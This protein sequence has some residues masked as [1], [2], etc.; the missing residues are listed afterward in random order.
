MKNQP[1]LER[2][3]H[4][5][6]ALPWVGARPTLLALVE[7]RREESKFE[8]TADGPFGDRQRQALLAA[9]ET[10]GMRISVPT[11]AQLGS[12]DR[13]RPDPTGLGIGP[14][15]GGVAV[16]M[17]SL[18]WSDADSGWNCDWRIDTDGRPRSWSARGV[19]F[20]EGFRAGVGGAA[21]ELAARPH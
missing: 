2:A 16:L 4:S 6:R 5:L 14:D 3:F 9:G 19:S 12:M 8:M 7:V 20:D 21:K 1:G 13:S 15:E 11:V 18:S 10:Y 17:G